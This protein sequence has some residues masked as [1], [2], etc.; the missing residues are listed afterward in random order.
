MAQEEV[1]NLTQQI[2]A[3]DPVKVVV[4]CDSK[5]TNVTLVPTKTTHPPVS[6][7]PLPTRPPPDTVCPGATV[8]NPSTSC[9]AILDCDPSAPSGYYW[10]LTRVPPQNRSSINQVYCYMETDKCAVKGMM[11]VAHID[12]RN[13]S[14][15]CPTPSLST[16]WTQERDCV[17]QTT[18]QE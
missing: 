3:R 1:Y 4:E 10:L 8:S 15:N 11:R 17:D 18:L 12:M 5:Q 16:N 13:T 6:P 2:Q 14:V 7:T 9:R